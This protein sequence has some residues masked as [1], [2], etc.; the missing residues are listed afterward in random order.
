MT[1][2]Q[3]L[4]E[5]VQ[6]LDSKGMV[7]NLVLTNPYNGNRTYGTD[8]Q[9]DRL[10]KYVV[11]ALCRVHQRD[12]G[13]FATSGNAPTREATRKIKPTSTVLAASFAAAIPGLPTA[14]LC[15]RCR[16]TGMPDWKYFSA[17]WPTHVILQQ[18]CP[19]TINP[20]DNG[21]EVSNAG[22][23]A[24]S[25]HNMPVVNDEYGYI[26]NPGMS[27][28][29]SRHEI[30]GIATAGGYGSEG[31]W[32][33]ISDGSTSYRPAESGDWVDA[34]EYGDIKRLV[35]FFTTKGIEYWKMASHNELKT[36]GT[37]TYVLAEPGRQ[38]VV[39]AAIGG[40][41]SLN[42]AA[43]TYYAYQYNPRTGETTQSADGD[44]RRHA[45]LHHARLERLGA[46]SQHVSR[47]SGTIEHRP[48][49]DDGRSGRCMGDS[50]TASSLNQNI[51]RAYCNAVSA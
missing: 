10:V 35:D 32:R 3:K 2:W 14:H 27:Q 45:L 50:T 37:R 36:A 16:S 17:T 26:A 38:Y 8:A 23:S 31:D 46:A 41:F 12:V 28:L 5:V 19:W 51:L 29:R 33:M 1:Y 34:P 6:Y 25:S 22:S 49:V 39:Y 11:V 24:T 15:G 20:T 4:D 43:G 21:D 30:W 9:N 44:R 7:A 47:G 48:A 42:L 13:T 40:T 18:G